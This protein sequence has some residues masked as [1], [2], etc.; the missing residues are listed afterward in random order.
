MAAWRRAYA[1]LLAPGYLAT[2]SVDE[3]THHWG[4]VLGRLGDERF[5]VIEAVGRLADGRSAD[6][7]V[8]YAHAGPSR[9]GDAGPATGALYS[10]Y[11]QPDEWG[12]GVGRQLHDAVVADL[13]E[14]GY[15]TATLWVLGT[16]RRARQFYRRQGWSMERATRTQE[17][18]GHTVVDFR[19]GR[20]LGD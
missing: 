5:T 6:G 15:R 19:Y 7:V 13:T 8:G 18:P 14:D 10:F 17:F 3:R 1:G 11:L 4:D 12:A 9:D 20:R 2:L 16:N